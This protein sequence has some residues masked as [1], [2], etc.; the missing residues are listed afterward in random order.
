MFSHSKFSATDLV[1][2]PERLH[3]YLLEQDEIELTKLKRKKIAEEKAA[4][5][6][7][8]AAQEKAAPTQPV[9]SPQHAIPAPDCCTKIDGPTYAKLMRAI[10]AFPVKYPDYKT[11]PPKLDEDVRDWMVNELG[12]TKSKEDHVFGMIVKEHFKLKG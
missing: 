1:S 8:M 11:N 3:A 4:L 2:F 9:E 12:F 5:I 10:E 7:E 6:Q